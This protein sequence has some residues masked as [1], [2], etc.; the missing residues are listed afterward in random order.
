LIKLAKDKLD[1]PDWVTTVEQTLAREQVTKAVMAYN[2]AQMSKHIIANG[3]SAR[4]KVE[5][6]Q[7]RSLIND[8][9][10]QMS[11]N[12]LKKQ[13]INQT[14]DQIWSQFVDKCVENVTDPES[15]VKALCKKHKIVL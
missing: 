12:E 5:F 3:N 4:Q 14:K 11:Y 7:S 15:H 1:D 10:S 13:K 6:N 8:L 9:F 2:Q